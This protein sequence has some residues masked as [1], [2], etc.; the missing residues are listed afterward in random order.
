MLEA[1]QI[2][3][4]YRRIRK[5][6]QYFKTREIRL[7]KHKNYYGNIYMFIKGKFRYLGRVSKYIIQIAINSR[8]QLIIPF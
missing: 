4:K 3:F 2:I 6:K 7:K 5:H 8:I 1:E